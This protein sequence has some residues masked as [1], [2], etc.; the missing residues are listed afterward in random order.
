MVEF[1]SNYK[2]FA[3]LKYDARIVGHGAFYGSSLCGKSTLVKNLCLNGMFQHCKTI[4]F[5]NGKT[6]AM[7][8][9]YVCPRVT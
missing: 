4:V 2:N 6:S 1:V 9:G 8:K 5:L 7:P 3:G